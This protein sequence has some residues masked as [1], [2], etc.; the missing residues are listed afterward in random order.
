MNAHLHP[1]GSVQYH[2]HDSRHERFVVRFNAGAGV[3]VENGQHGHPG[4]GITRYN[5]DWMLREI[6]DRT[7][8][9]R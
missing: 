1:D 2:R 5:R 3:L 8:D 4:Y 7:R 9:G 6:E